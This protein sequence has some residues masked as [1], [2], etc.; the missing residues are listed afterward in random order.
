M[1]S[2]DAE[3]LKDWTN[4]RFSFIADYLLQNGED[5]WTAIDGKSGYI[6][7]KVAGDDWI[8]FH[9][10]FR[11]GSVMVSSEFSGALIPKSVIT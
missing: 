11:N 9:D 8:F 5:A 2:D 10:A 7:L 6:S 4:E 3:N 1:C